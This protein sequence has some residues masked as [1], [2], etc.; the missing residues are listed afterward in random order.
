[1]VSHAGVD[2]YDNIELQTSHGDT[3]PERILKGRFKAT[4]AV[5]PRQAEFSPVVVTV[6]GKS[7]YEIN[8]GKYIDAR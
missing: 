3:G 4:I 8:N 1:M 2:D 6:T 5:T 7:A